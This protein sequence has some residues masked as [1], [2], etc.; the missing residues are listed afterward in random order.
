[1]VS[2][3]DVVLLHRKRTRERVTEYREVPR[4]T[5]LTPHELPLQV[6]PKDRLRAA[7]ASTLP[8]VPL[9][10]HIRYRQQHKYETLSRPI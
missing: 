9:P 10:G 4:E 5:L 3:E 1:M 6:K 2:K 7:F 8:A